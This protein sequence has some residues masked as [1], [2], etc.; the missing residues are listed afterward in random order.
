L[1]VSPI[2]YAMVAVL[3]YAPS[4]VT[5]T[6]SCTD[7]APPIAIEPI[8][9]VTTPPANVPPLLALTNVEPAG[10][11]SLIVASCATPLPVLL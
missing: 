11:A 8:A 9:Q 10:I 5:P 7:P 4:A 6:V 2:L 1:V 3:A